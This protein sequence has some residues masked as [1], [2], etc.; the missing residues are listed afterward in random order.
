MIN[1]K[2]LGCVRRPGSAIRIL[3]R[4]AKEWEDRFEF[5]APPSPT[6]S[7]YLDERAKAFQIIGPSGKRNEPRMASFHK[8]LKAG[9]GDYR[10]DQLS[11]TLL[12]DYL[13][14]RPQSS[15]RREIEE[16]RAAIPKKE[17]ISDFPLPRPRP[18]REHFLSKQEA[19]RL[20]SA[21]TVSHAKLFIMLAITTTGQ[22]AGAILG[23]TW[24]R[25]L[26]DSGVIDFQDPEGGIN[27]KKRGV[28]PVDSRMLSILRDAYQIRL[29]SYVIEYNGYPVASIKKTFSTAAINA[30]LD[31]S[32][33]TEDGKT[34]K[35]ASVSPHILKHSVI[36]WLAMDGWTIDAISDFTSTDAKTI[37]RI[38][39]K[40]NPGYLRGLATSLGDGLFD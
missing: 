38:Y 14:T 12:R 13:E 33:Q 26:W 16:L 27:R 34:R 40:V 9:L 2:E 20:L 3:E 30:G 39:R 28:C 35:Q 24:D 22:R 21:T 10:P 32:V 11:E 36:S 18:P 4:H 19:K 15:G 29:T 17:R 5:P 25:V 6:V 37:K 7:W 1:Q 31:K 8:A 23:L